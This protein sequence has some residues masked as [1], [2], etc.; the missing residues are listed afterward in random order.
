VIPAREA[1]REL[2]PGLAAVAAALAPRLIALAAGVDRVPGLSRDLLDGNPYL[3]P[4]PLPGPPA[5]AVVGLA[6][7]PHPGRQGARALDPP[8]RQRARP[9]PAAWWGRSVHRARTRP[10]RRRAQRPRLAALARGSPRPRSPVWARAG[11]RI[12]P[13]G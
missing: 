9:R 2:T 5:L 3:P 8:G 12:L 10:S 1:M 13:I 7:T 11:V 4:A 6:L